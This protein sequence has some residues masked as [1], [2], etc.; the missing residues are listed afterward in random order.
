MH[1]H[2]LTF[3]RGERF[4]NASLRL[5]KEASYTQI[6]DFIHVYNDKNLRMFTDFWKKH[7]KFLENNNRM[8]GY[9]IWKPYLI[10]QHLECMKDG[11]VLLYADSGCE[12]DNYC[13]NPKEE[14]LKL[15]PQLKKYKIIASLCN[16]EYAMTKMDLVCFLD[17]QSNPSYNLD[18]RQATCIMFEKCK[19]TLDLVKEWYNICCNY[20]MVSDDKSL[21]KNHPKFDEH[22]HEQSV[23]SMLTK[24]YD[25]YVKPHSVSVESFVSLSRNRSGN[26]RLAPRILGS[27]FYCGY[28]S[29]KDYFN[30]LQSCHI[31][32]IV[33]KLKPSYI[34]ELGFLSART[35]TSIVES[36][37]YNEKC[38][39]KYL[40][41]DKNYS[42]ISVP[43][44]KYFHAILK[45]HFE[46]LTIEKR[47]QDLFQ[48]RFLYNEFPNGVDL[49]V[50]DGDNTYSGC[51]TDLCT[52]FPHINKDGIV[53]IVQYNR[54][55]QII[56]ACDIFYTLVKDKVTRKLES[57]GNRTICWFIKETL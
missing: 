15:L 39:K 57:I 21:L 45:H 9:G 19:R 50:F 51:L 27:N 8:Y 49:F 23:F 52:V 17:M 37:L 5:C 46:F 44:R 38:I 55:E 12:F 20:H 33:K 3:G 14:Y 6:F 30:T 28:V 32:R 16:F 2:L 1:H 13:E 47:S 10:L 31:S 35:T 29:D 4:I 41:C 48:G 36:L 24:K 42:G 7:G 22:R 43:Y 25:L 40:N 54:N 34:I 53:Y 56:Q 11:D 26:H 18:Q